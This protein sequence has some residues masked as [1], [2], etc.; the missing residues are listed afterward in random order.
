[1][2]K[3]KNYQG[4]KN[5]Y[6]CEN[7]HMTVTLDKDSGV[8]PLQIRCRECGEEAKSKFYKV[9]Q[10]LVPEFEWVR[11][12]DDELIQKAMDDLQDMCLC[13]ITKALDS[14]EDPF[15]FMYTQIKQHHDRNGLFLKEIKHENEN[16][17]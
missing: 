12:S 7:G 3:K 15:A 2:K 13:C 4:M 17:A 14:K 5:V 8:I 10:N 9:D 6:E 11:L 1:M 16:N